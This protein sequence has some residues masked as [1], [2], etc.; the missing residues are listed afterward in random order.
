M[1]VAGLDLVWLQPSRWRAIDLNLGGFGRMICDNCGVRPASVQVFRQ[2]GGQRVSNY[3][4]TQCARELG[5]IGS[6]AGGFD[7]F[8]ILQNL[9]QQQQGSS[10]G[11]PFNALSR[12]AQEAVM[13]AREASA[14]TTRTAAIGTDHL[15]AGIVTGDNVAT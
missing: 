3:L 7:P 11:S 15:L 5:M 4:C 10:G 2:Q 8:V 9:V 6:G 14:G 13:R 12:E 1:S